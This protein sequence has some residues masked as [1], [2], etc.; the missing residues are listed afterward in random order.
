MTKLSDKK[1]K[2]FTAA[3]TKYKMHETADTVREASRHY[4]QFVGM[5]T[6]ISMM[7]WEN[8]FDEWFLQNFHNITL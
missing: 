6:V 1:M 4:E 7:G 2:I 5:T 3:A 8:E